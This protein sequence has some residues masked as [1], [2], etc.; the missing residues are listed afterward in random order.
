MFFAVAIP[1]DVTFLCNGK[2]CESTAVVNDTVTCV[3]H[4]FPEPKFDLHVRHLSSGHENTSQN[5]QFNRNTTNEKAET[6]KTDIREV[7]ID[8]IKTS[9]NYCIDQKDVGQVEVTCNTSN[10]LGSGYKAHVLKVRS[11]KSEHYVRLRFS[12]HLSEYFL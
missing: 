5:Q 6:L 1:S 2:P 8:N 9:E 7:T 12:S 4:G 3:A 10:A 11:S